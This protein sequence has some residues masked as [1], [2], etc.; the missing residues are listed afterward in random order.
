MIRGETELSC[1]LKEVTAMSHNNNQEGFDKSV[2]FAFLF[3]LLF[4]ALQ[5]WKPDFYWN[6]PNIKILRYRYG[7]RALDIWIY[8]IATISLLSILEYFTKKQRN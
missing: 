2:P 3:F 5:Y 8:G 7:D 6:S 4:F 1:L